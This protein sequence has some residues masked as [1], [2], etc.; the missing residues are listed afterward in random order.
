MSTAVVAGVGAELGLGAALCRRFAREGYHVLVAGRTP[1]KIDQ[2]A[3]SIERTGGRATPFPTDVTREE[4][5]I[6]LFDR[7]MTGGGASQAADLAAY[8]QTLAR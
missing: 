1:A 6:A 4:D 3:A 2:V 7:A 5:V 8:I